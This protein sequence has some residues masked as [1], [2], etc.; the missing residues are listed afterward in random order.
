VRRMVII[1]RFMKRTTNLICIFLTFLFITH[2]KSQS[3]K[4]SV[5]FNTNIYSGRAGEKTVG[6]L[7]S[8]KE[9]S[10]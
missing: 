1:Y 5:E 2:V 3:I 8:I 6:N 9:F 7:I 4:L 10:N